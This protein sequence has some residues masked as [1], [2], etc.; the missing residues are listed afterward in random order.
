M[1]SV[2][3]MTLV[4]TAVGAMAALVGTVLAYK[5]RSRD[6][7]GREFR[8]ER[9]HSYL[10]FLSAMDAA[11]GALRI[12]ADSVGADRRQ[13]GGQAMSE[14]RVYEAREKLLMSASPAV[15]TVGEQAF[16]RLGDLRKAI[17]DGARTG[18]REYHDPYHVFAASLWRLRNAMRVDLGGT[19]LTPAD[20]DKE[21]WD[22]KAECIVCQA[23]P[24]TVP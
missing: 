6:E 5:V 10:D 18:E 1:S 8:V 14:S 20:L 4:S 11:H 22:G 24:A 21:S 19:A 13:T 2:D 3:W 7:A 12:V 23:Q 16:R 17:R 9:R 15:V